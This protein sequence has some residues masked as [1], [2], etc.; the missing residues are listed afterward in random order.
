MR[1]KVVI[2]YHIKIS[3]RFLK[4]NLWSKA[5][6]YWDYKRSDSVEW[7]ENRGK[8]YSYLSKKRVKID[9]KWTN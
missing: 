3:L 7:W 1:E 4:E 9:K 5:S 6:Q 2:S 8:K